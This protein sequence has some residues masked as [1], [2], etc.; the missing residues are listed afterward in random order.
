MN[1][2]KPD[3]L[4]QSSPYDRAE[5]PPGSIDPLGTATGAEQLAEVLL[6]HLTARMW[7][8]R[9][10]TFAALAAEVS[11]RVA[12]SREVSALDARLAF[13]RL[14]LSALARQEA[15][16]DSWRKA[17]RRLPGIGLARKALRLGDQ[18][19]EQA[20]FLKGQAVNGPCGVIARLARDVGVVD[21]EGKLGETELLSAWAEDQKLPGLLDDHNAREG[22]KWLKNLV[23]QVAKCL[24]VSGYWPGQSWSGWE[25][26]AR[27]LR[28]D[29][30]GPRE[31]HVLR[32]F[33]L[34]DHLGIRRR[35]VER[36]AEPQMIEVYRREKNGDAERAVLVQG[37]QSK[38]D[39]MDRTLC[40][41]IALIDAYESVSGL[42]ETIFRGLLWSLTR[43]NGHASRTVIVGEL[44]FQSVMAKAVSEMGPAADRLQK[45]IPAFAADALACERRSVDIERMNGVLEVARAASHDLDDAVTA[46]MDRHR[47]TQNEKGKGVWIEEGDRW[48]LMSGFGDTA[49]AP[50]WF[51][52]Y[53]HPYRV[54]N[55]YSLL[56]DLKLVPEEELSDDE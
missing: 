11:Q 7:R 55:V 2:L 33:L 40:A 42:L 43:N 18:P 4:P 44:Q 56:A 9:F 30:I 6:P 25:D 54:R 48:A 49:E 1:T 38:S 53:L 37:F 15:S 52:F 26:L 20:N 24:D 14:F 46:V 29:E 39:D 19:L 36:L 16:D 10:L 51:D 34:K 3:F 13:E 32:R 45:A 31:T 23:R 22:A 17:T 27:I 50:K 41:T 12:E 5:D 8:A 21:L 28:P 35:V 47:K